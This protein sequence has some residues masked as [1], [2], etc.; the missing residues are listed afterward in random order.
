MPGLA[1]LPIAHPMPRASGRLGV[2]RAI[3][4]ACGAEAWPRI[5]EITMES[6]GKQR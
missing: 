4:D 5:R 6:M 1:L 3:S 2:S